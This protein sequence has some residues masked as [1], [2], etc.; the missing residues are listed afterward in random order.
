MTL[1]GGRFQSPGTFHRGPSWL[2]HIETTCPRHIPARR[3]WNR[4][5]LTKY[6][7]WGKRATSLPQ[8][9]LPPSLIHPPTPSHPPRKTE[10]WV[11]ACRAKLTQ[12]PAGGPARHRWRPFGKLTA[13]SAV[14]LMFLLHCYL[15][16]I[17]SQILTT[18][19]SPRE[20]I[21]WP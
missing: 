5:T 8:F 1:L 9:S 15:F 14:A 19:G 3:K 21:L 16:L 11:R 2:S 13:F 4:A 10:R 17:F 6:K 18:L 12:A 20:F 7:S